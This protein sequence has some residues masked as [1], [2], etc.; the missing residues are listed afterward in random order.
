MITAGRRSAVRAEPRQSI[1]T[2]LAMPVDSSVVSII[3][4]PSTRSSYPT[5]PSISVRIGR[6]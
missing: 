2:R 6:E 3:D 5:T 4:A 1:T